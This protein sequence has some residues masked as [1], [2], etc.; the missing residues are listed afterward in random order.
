M[1]FGI[2]F[3]KPPSSP[4]NFQLVYKLNDGKS[5]KCL[6]IP[7]MN[8]NLKGFQLKVI[9]KAILYVLIRGMNYHERYKKGLF[10]VNRLFHYLFLIQG[11]LLK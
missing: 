3:R 9:F 1:N 4:L 11:Y 6:L 2:N 10:V 5:N 7:N 8:W